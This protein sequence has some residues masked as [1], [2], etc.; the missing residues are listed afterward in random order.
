MYFINQLSIWR[1]DDKRF[2]TIGASVTDSVLRSGI[3]LG[4][5]STPPD[6]LDMQTKLAW[7]NIFLDWHENGDDAGTHSATGWILRTWHVA[8]PEFIYSAAPIADRNWHVN[9]T[10]ITM[11]KIPRGSFVRKD[12]SIRDSTS[13]Q[14]DRE[15]KPILQTVTLT[16]PFLISDREVSVGLF[17]QMMDDP[18]FPVGAK[19][20]DFPGADAD[21]SPTPDHPVQRTNWNDAAQFCNW[22]S[23]KEGLMPCYER[24]GKVWQIPS[25]KFEEWRLIPGGDGYRLPTEAEWEYACRADTDTDFVSGNDERL[26]WQYAVFAANRPMICGSK[27]PN[28]WGLFDAHGNVRE[29]CQDWYALYG[30]ESAV[31]DPLGPARHS[32]LHRILRGH[33]Y[34]AAPAAL[35]SAYRDRHA[36]TVRDRTTGFRVART[37][38][39][40]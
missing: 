3:C 33:A 18:N 19:P 35:R 8:L 1:G 24:T 25:G 2:A 11:L 20:V 29:W 26:L 23:Y 5:G 10:G 38:P 37:L 28:G 15:M 12:D 17:Q 9:G 16:R 14:Q 27:L 30:D 7:Q 4:I 21:N 22:L 32:Q 36:H 13:R 6:R 39:S 31:V 40:S 34:S